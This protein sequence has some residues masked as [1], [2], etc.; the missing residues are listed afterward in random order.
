[1]ATNESIKTDI[2][3]LDVGSELVDMY[4]LDATIFGGAVYYFTPMTD[5][6]ITD[7]DGVKTIR[8]E[9]V[10]FNG[11]TYLPIPVEFSGME[12]PGDGTLPRPRMKVSNVTL[13]FLGLI[14][15]YQDAVGAKVTRI[16]TFRKYIDGHA[17]ADAT[18]QFP[19]DIFYIEQKLMQ[20]KY[21]IEWELVS[22]L[23][24]GNKMLPRNQ[25]LSSCGHAYRVWKDG[26]FVTTYATCPYAG[27]NYFTA[28]GVVT[29]DNLDKCGKRLSDCELRYPLTT[30]Q[31]PFKG[32]PGVGLI[33]RQYR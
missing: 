25:V 10:V 12:T 16:R 11:I 26:A 8:N 18:A 3:R 19:A 22:P 4:S 14:N 24:I 21:F 15:A 17:G 33:G 28:S 5:P 2:Q 23:D 20:T 9:A 6:V 30:D 27:T 29:T 1:M 32:F 31:L 7:V 13:T